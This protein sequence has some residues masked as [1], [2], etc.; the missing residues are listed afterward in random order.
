MKVFVVLGALIFLVVAAA[1]AYRL[2]S[3]LSVVVGDHVIPMWVS[4]PGAIVTALLGV[5]L[6]LESRR[7]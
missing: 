6:L 3:H 4:W 2:Y 7:A 5:A 1:H